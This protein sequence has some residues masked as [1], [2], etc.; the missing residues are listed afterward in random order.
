MLYLCFKKWNAYQKDIKGSEQLS[1]I[2]REPQLI[3]DVID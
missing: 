3:A 1:K 2:V